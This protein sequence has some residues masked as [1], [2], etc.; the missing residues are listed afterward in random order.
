MCVRVPSG[1][2]IKKI[3]RQ[4]TNIS[5]ISLYLLLLACVSTCFRLLT[6]WKYV[7]IIRYGQRFVSERKCRC[8]AQIGQIRARQARITTGFVVVPVAGGGGRQKRT[9]C[10]IRACCRVGANFKAD[11][12]L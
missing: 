8:D 6:Y 4:S 1:E 12:L 9:G 10:G 7:Q 2:S 3:R 5:Y 11:L